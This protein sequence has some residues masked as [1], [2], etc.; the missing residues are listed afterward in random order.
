MAVIIPVREGASLFQLEKL[1]C[2]IL[3]NAVKLEESVSTLLELTKD[4]A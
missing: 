3:S 2:V 1:S 4:K